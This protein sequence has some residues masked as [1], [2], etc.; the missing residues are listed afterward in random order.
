MQCPICKSKQ[1]GKVGADH[2]YCWSCFIEFTVR[3]GE[4]FEIEED[5]SLV[6]LDHGKGY[7]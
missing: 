7:F 5:G 4:V 2:Y 1:V 3:S 6:A